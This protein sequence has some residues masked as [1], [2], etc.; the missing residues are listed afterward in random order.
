LFCFVLFFEIAWEVG[1]ASGTPAGEEGQ[2]GAFL[3]SLC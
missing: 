1:I 2:L 3:A